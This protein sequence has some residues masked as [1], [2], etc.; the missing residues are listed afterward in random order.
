MFQ[1]DWAKICR[2]MALFD[3]TWPS[4]KRRCGRFGHNET[5]L[6]HLI[7]A[8]L[9]LPQIGAADADRRDKR[10]FRRKLTERPVL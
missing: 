7:A 1:P 4:V 2:D 6:L 10:P 9:P 3:L 5:T 8:S